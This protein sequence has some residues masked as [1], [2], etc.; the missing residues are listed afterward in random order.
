MNKFIVT[1]RAECA[2]GREIDVVVNQAHGPEEYLSY[3]LDPREKG[4]C[5]MSMMATVN[6]EEKSK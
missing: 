4:F 2:C 5:G 3:H 6:T 1:A